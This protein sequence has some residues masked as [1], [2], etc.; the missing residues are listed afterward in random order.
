MKKRSRI[1]IETADA[2]GQND[3]S[4]SGYS[5]GVR[6]FRISAPQF[7]QESGAVAWT[8]V[9]QLK[10]SYVDS[11]FGSS[12]MSFMGETMDG[13]ALVV[14]AFRNNRDIRMNLSV[15]YLASTGERGSIFNHQ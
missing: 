9:P 15:S 12:L 7:G 4:G 8:T 13:L 10:H 3:R 14:D 1:S 6:R 5:I 2:S 11:V